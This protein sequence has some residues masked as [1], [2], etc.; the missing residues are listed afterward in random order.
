MCS[1]VPV[2]Q[3]EEGGETVFPYANEDKTVLSESDRGNVKAYGPC[4]QV[5]KGAMKVPAQKGN[6]V[7]FYSMKPE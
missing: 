2:H 5:R 3:V 7:I 1:C 6:A 4:E